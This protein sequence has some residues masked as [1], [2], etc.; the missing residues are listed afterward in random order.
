[1]STRER[2]EFGFS[3]FAKSMTAAL[4]LPVVMTAPFLVPKWFIRWLGRGV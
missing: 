3:D 2:R 4:L 1:M